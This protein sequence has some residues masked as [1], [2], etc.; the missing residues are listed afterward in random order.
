MSAASTPALDYPRPRPDGY[1]DNAFAEALFRTA[2]HRPE[3][4][5]SGFATLNEARQCA[6]R[7]VRWCV[8]VSASPRVWDLA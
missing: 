3:F 4:P 8:S 5:N 7:F 1:D 2:K 6:A